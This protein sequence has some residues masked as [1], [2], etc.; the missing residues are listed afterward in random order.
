[1][2][3]RTWIIIDCRDSAAL[4]GVDN[5]TLRFSTEEVANEV[6]RQFFKKG[7]DYIVF[8]ISNVIK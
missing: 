5:K 4:Y 3:T 2:E 7:D 1:M 6:A 8:N